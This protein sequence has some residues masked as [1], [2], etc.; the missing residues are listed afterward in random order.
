MSGEAATLIELMPLD[1]VF[2][3]RSVRALPV[4]HG[5]VIPSGSNSHDG[6]HE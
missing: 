2:P 5:P 1:P 3:E 4:R 6:R